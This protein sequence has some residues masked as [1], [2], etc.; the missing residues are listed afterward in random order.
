MSPIRPHRRTRRSVGLVFALVV[1]L[2][3]ACDLTP[4]QDAFYTPPDPLPA[5]APGDVLRSRSSTFTLDPVG[6]TPVPGVNSWQVLYRS[7]NANGQPMAVSGTVLVP[8]TPWL[9]LGQR[10]IVSYAVGT[11]GVGDAC[12]PSYTLSQGTDY[13]G[14]FISSLLAQGWAVAVTDYEGLGTPGVHT[15]MVGQSQG[16]AVLDVARAAQRLPGTG[17]SSRNPVALFGYSQGGGAAG[18]AAELAPTYGSGINLK[19]VVAGGIPGDLTK[20]AD[21]HEGTPFVGL[22]LLA[23]IGLDTA[24]PELDLDSYLNDRGRDLMEEADDLCLVSLDGIAT[25][26]STAFSTRSDYT[27]TD[28]L[29]TPAWQSRLAENKLGSGR[30]NVPVYQYHGVVDEMV[31]YG[32]ARDLRRSWCNRGT[33]V[34][35]VPLPAEHVLGLVEGAP[36]A[37]TWLHARFLGVPTL[38]TCWLP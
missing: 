3:S 6:Q 9:G 29:S 23:S 30:P 20:V 37:I 7:E 11:R 5:S 22:T 36:G 34:T 21:F 27:T 24:Y 1:V 15:Y 19:A 28:P 26:F 31:P 8:S 4:D 35:W 12:A 13:E 25:I 16:K 32:Q 2:L 38:G 14:L 10:P 17:L 33:N 18:W